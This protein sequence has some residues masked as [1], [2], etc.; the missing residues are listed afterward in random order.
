M[1]E[2]SRDTELRLSLHRV[3][4]SIDDIAEQAQ[5]IKNILVKELPPACDTDEEDLT[6][7]IPPRT[8]CQQMVETVTMQSSS[9]Q[10]VVQ[11]DIHS[12]R[13]YYFLFFF[14]IFVVTFFPIPLH[15]FIVIYFVFIIFF[16]A[17]S[18][19]SIHPFT[20]LG[21]GT[22]TEDEE[23]EDGDD[24]DDKDNTKKGKKISL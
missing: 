11:A 3:I 8:T 7:P 14:F 12:E 22:D 13:M 20:P 17:P 21:G 4:E 1:L 10:M 24:H 15:M 6:T 5:D 19:I 18:T 2:E 16:P 9:H 23:E